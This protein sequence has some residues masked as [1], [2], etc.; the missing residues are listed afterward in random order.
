MVAQVS[1]DLLDP[2]GHQGPL[3]PRD[4]TGST[5][6]VASPGSSEDQGRSETPDLKERED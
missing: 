4:R 2:L 3:A 6:L 5:G 1:W